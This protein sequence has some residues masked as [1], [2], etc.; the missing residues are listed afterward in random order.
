MYESRS[1]HLRSLHPRSPHPWSS[2]PRSP[3]P[4]S[5]HPRSSHHPDRLIAR[6]TCISK[7]MTYNH[8]IHTFVQRVCMY[9][10]YMYIL[11]SILGSL[12]FP[13][14]TRYSQGTRRERRS[15]VT[16]SGPKRAICLN[17]SIKSE[18]DMQSLSEMLHSLYGCMLQ[19]LVKLSL[20]CLLAA[21]L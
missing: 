1:S 7:Y 16:H 2:H 13:V 5:H 17:E 21:M 14:L 20:S 12:V 8:L 6:K 19:L 15:F 18:I 10:K 9:I 11:V 3:H 4:R